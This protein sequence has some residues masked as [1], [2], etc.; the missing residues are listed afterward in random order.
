MIRG[1]SILSSVRRDNGLI[2]KKA[3]WVTGSS[4]FI[5]SWTMHSLVRKGIPVL[6]LDMLPR[7]LWQDSGIKSVPTVVAPCDFVSL[8]VTAERYGIPSAII[9][10]AGSGSVPFSFDDPR[11]DFLA[12]VQT[13]MEVLDFSRHHKS[14]IAIVLPSSAAVYGTAQG[15]PQKESGATGPISPYGAHKLMAEG[16]CRS[17]GRH[18][19][20]SSA[21]IRF[22]SV[23]GAGLRK[24]LLWDAC[25][26]ARSGDFSFSGSG[27]E[28]R[29][30]LQ[31]TDAA[32][33]LYI[34]LQ[35]ASADCPT[36]NG[37]TG[38]G[39]SVKEILQQIGRQW[40]PPQIPVFNGTTR[41]GDPTHYT[42]DISAAREWG[43][44]PRRSLDESISEYLEWFK[45][46]TA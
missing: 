28:R 10:C 17:Y 35:K 43:F 7:A 16:L 42:A 27:E 18:F 34:A 12:N 9:H 1:G 3:I 8:S 32:E 44:I 29:D 25:R 20:V 6:G 37:G 11:G 22:F 30:F 19:G 21:V 38:I 46:D 39:T 33:L 41:N 23:Y 31:V 45:K 24:Q 5:G 40:D 15:E 2:M 26:K 14:A 4:G 36:V 13:T